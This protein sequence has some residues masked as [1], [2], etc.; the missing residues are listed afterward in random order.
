MEL[1]EGSLAA[2]PAGLRDKGALPAVA[3]P[4]RASHRIGDP[5]AVD[6]RSRTDTRFVIRHRTVF[7]IHAGGSCWRTKL[8]F[9]DLFEEQREGALEDRTGI[10]GRDLA[11]QQALQLSQPL[12]ALLADGEL[13]PVPLRG[14]WLD[15]RA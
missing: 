15:D 5:P 10:A 11:T 1:Q 9:L 3:R 7:P 13:H 14:Q 6:I 2:P 4:D 8:L 12:L